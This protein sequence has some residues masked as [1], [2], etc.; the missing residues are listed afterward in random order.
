MPR[1]DLH[2]HSALSSCAENIMSPK[3]ILE[4]A[5]RHGV[6]VVSIT[7]HNAC[8]AAPVAAKLA[9]S[10]NIRYVPGIEITTREEVHLLAYFESLDALVDFQCLLD[11]HLPELSNSPDLYGYQIIYDENDEIVDADDRLRQTAVAI[12]IDNLVREIRVRNGFPVPAHVF[13]KRNSLTSQLG[14]IDP[15]ADYTAVEVAAP[16]WRREGYRIGQRIAGFPAITGSDAHFLEDIGQVAIDLDAPLT[17]SS[18]LAQLLQA[19]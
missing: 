13:R 5:V 14:F 12:G 4:S 11:A 1:Y 15:N 10:L 16:R 17:R 7:D 8:A 3:R 19:L 6:D 18:P 2:V 9:D